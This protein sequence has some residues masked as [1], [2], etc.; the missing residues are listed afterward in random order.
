MKKK[1]IILIIVA[2]ILA[3]GL[4]IG[5]YFYW[6]SSRNVISTGQQKALN[7]AMN[8]AESLTDSINRGILPDINTNPLENQ[9]EINP[10]S[11]NPLKD[12]RVNP[13]E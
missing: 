1:T 10:A 3:I 13:F 12:L 6:K 7:D 8:A 5:G 9:P 2:V 11:A 4:S